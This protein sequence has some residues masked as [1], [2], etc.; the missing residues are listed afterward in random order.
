MSKQTRSFLALSLVST[1]LTSCASLPSTSEPQALR[2]VTVSVPS[3]QSGPLPDREPDLLVRDYFAANANPTQQNQ[4]ARSYL[5]PKF[6]QQ[7]APQPEIIVLDRI[8]MSSIADSSPDEI[9]Y[10]IN[11]TWIGTVGEGGAYNPRK[12]EY[13]AK[14]SLK[15]IDGQ[16]RIS[17]APQQI[18]VE[19]TELRN[20][21]LPYDIYYFAP[22]G[23]SLVTDRRWMYAGIGALDS[24]LISLVTA[25]PS[26]VIAPGVL[27]EIPEGASYAGTEDGIYQLVGFSGFTEDARRRLAAQL[28]WTLARAGINGPY[29]FNI[30][31]VPLL[32]DKGEP[33]LS[34][35]DFPEYN[36][37]TTSS[38]SATL[39]GLVGG[40]VVKISAGVAT[41]A[42]GGIG[43]ETGVESV[44]ISTTAEA[45]AAVRSRGEG[46][47]KTAVLYVGQLEEPLTE[48]FE[49]HTLSRPTFEIYAPAVWVVV[50]N[51]TITRVARSNATDEI[52]QTEVD[53][54]ELGENYGDIT[55][56]RLS[57]SGV[58]AGFIMDGRVYT[59]TV[60]RPAAGERKL[61]NIKET[62][63]S[64]GA[65]ALSIEW[66]N[67]ATLLIGTSNAD[68]PV[69]RAEVD[70]SSAS[71]LA[72]G[73]IVA[74]VV[75]IAASASTL[76]VT[77]A[78][79]ALQI[80]TTGQSTYWREVQG[81]EGAR[82]LTIVPR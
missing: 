44:D 9:S 17:Q 67:D 4:Q 43:F 72:N 29:R 22:N 63:P 35:D 12:E 30:D 10:A 40:K 52:A 37:Q 2:S 31:G 14:V 61:V 68:T 60:A 57:S 47:E 45:V 27:D 71:P 16:W 58:R 1:M 80:S 66:G 42:P 78:R 8:D 62:V 73:N 51:K 50:N 15:K 24:A 11:G 13:S 34:I 28:V 5:T 36:P 79:A 33:T 74:P 21:Y 32:S 75:S 39:Y 53:I 19:R 65:T 26:G 70:G 23:S 55:S 3:E 7:W 54:S 41:P 20:R 81:L 6:A 82:S 38:T 64:I 77:D 18:I 56:F 48:V 46:P 76:Y 69:W 49:A 25:G 59:A